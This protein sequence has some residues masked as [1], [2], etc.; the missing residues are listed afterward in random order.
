MAKEAGD[1]PLAQGVLTDTALK[2]AAVPIAEAQPPSQTPDDKAREPQDTS[3]RMLKRNLLTPVIKLAQK[4]FDDPYDAPAVFAVLRR[5]AD[6]KVAP[7]IGVAP[8]GIKWRDS[9]DDPQFLSL[10]NL[11]ERLKRQKKSEQTKD[12]A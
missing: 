7:M 4:E 11:R 2:L 3:H 12:V 10:K 8:E 5:M 1:S 9:N 6:E